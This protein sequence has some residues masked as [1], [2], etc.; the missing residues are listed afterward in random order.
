MCANA[1]T[2]IPDE[3][4]RQTCVRELA[5]VARRRARLVVTAQ[6]LSIKKKRAGYPREGPAR[7]PSGKVH[8]IYRYEAEE[9]RSTLA[10]TMTVDKIRGAGLPLV[11]RWK[12]SGLS[13]RLE[14]LL[15][16]FGASAQW[17]N[18][19]VGIGHKPET[20]P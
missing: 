2:Q 5:R 17:G 13:R 10:S 14:R 6:N 7:G 20:Q 3:N 16:R 4:L 12:L 1:I 19:L 8:Y 11:Y 9:F 15:R 18:M